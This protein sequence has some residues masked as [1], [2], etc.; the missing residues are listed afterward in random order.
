MIDY[1]NTEINISP[2]DDVNSPEQSSNGVADEESQYDEIEY[3]PILME[4]IFPYYRDN[5]IEDDCKTQAAI[6]ENKKRAINLRLHQ[7]NKILS[8]L[9]EK[10]PRASQLNLYVAFLKS[11]MSPDDLLERIGDLDFQRAVREE[12]RERIKMSKRSRSKKAMKEIQQKITAQRMKEM[13]YSSESEIEEDTDSSSSEE[14]EAPKKRKKN[15]TYKRK[16]STKLDA[17]QNADYPCPPNIKASM[18]DT[19]SVARKKSY[20]TGMKN[21]NAYLYRH[22]PP[23]EK[24]SNG[25]WTKQ[26]KALFLARLQEMREEGI[27]TG[28]WGIFSQAIPGRVGYQ[29]ANFYRKLIAS[30]E[31]KDKDYHLDKDG[32]LRYKDRQPYHKKS[33]GLRPPSEYDEDSDSEPSKPKA[34]RAPRVIKEKAPVESMYDKMAKMNPFKNKT[35]CITGEIINVPA[36]SPDGTVLDY[37]T[38]M[39]ILTTTKQDP[40]T[41]KHINKRQIVI[42]TTENIDS[43]RNKIKHI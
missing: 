39:H 43:Y 36:I 31:I 27:K 11:D 26:E 42:L 16:T 18:W 29:C 4:D 23:G 38:W 33:S 30:G 2:V 32:N 12:S 9:Y 34:P 8:K 7:I 21:P 17:E 10:W 20:L 41:M 28:K 35:D 19:W 3:P 5:F 25:P 1:R 6:I 15:S 40:L 22:L 24:Q 37:N 14:D 13:D